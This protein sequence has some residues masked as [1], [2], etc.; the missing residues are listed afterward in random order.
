MYPDKQL[1]KQRFAKAA[2]TYEKQADVQRSVAKKLLVMLDQQLSNEPRSILEIGCCTG[3]L[4]SELA[5]RFPA[6]HQLIT[7]DLSSTFK[8]YIEEKTKA[9]NGAVKFISGDIETLDL[10]GCYDLIISSSTLHWLH[11]L[12]GFFHK[13]HNRIASTGILAFSLYGAENVREIKGITG[14]GLAYESMNTLLEILKKEYEVL[15]Y[16]QAVEKL[17]FPTPLEVL[18]HLRRTG[19]NALGSTTWSRKELRHFIEEYRKQYSGDNGVS[20]TYHPMYIVARP[21]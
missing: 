19:V 15:S 18:H 11:D 2:P 3:M 8:P 16:D 20:L 17:W 13:L 12:P 9:L 6:V 4:T 14:I 10:Q 5:I 1:I 21:K 7:T